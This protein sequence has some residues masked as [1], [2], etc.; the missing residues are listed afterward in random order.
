MLKDQTR[1][2]KGREESKENC[3]IGLSNGKNDIAIEIRRT[4]RE[5]GYVLGA[6]F[7][8]CLRCLNI[9]IKHPNGDA[10]AEGGHT[11][12]EFKGEVQARTIDLGNINA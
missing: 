4:A 3:Q 2:L 5:A 8:A 12:L 9:P 10:E 11:C 1:N 7:Y 6:H